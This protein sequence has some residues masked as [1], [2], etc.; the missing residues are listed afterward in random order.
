MSVNGFCPNIPRVF[1]FKMRHLKGEAHSVKLK[2]FSSFQNFSRRVDRITQ[3]RKRVF[4]K[5]M[6]W[7]LCKAIL[8]STYHVCVCARARALFSSVFELPAF[9]SGFSPVRLARK[10]N[11]GLSGTM[12]NSLV[13]RTFSNFKIFHLSGH[14]KLTF[15]NRFVMQSRIS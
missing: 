7:H 15:V 8:I 14:V 1:S 3:G 2:N 10:R 12:L 4:E 11:R 6:R 9:L 5:Q 13:L